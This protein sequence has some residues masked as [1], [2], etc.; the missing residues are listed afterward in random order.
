MVFY[1]G[2]YTRLGGA[3][4]AVCEYDSGAV[5]VKEEIRDIDDPIYLIFSPDGKYLFAVG[6]IKGSD[7]GAAASYCIGGDGLRLLS[8]KQTNGIEPCHMTL[9]AD[10]RFLYAAN[11]TTGSVAVLPVIEGILGEAVQMVRHEGK[12]VNPKRQERAHVHQCIFRPETNELFVC[13]LGIDKV[14]IYRQSPDT[15]MLAYESEIRMPDGMGPRHL[16]FYDKNRFFVVGELDNVLR[17]VENQ[18]GEWVITGEISTLPA[19]FS[20][21]STAA[22]L[23]LYKNAVWITNRGHDS[24]CRIELNDKGELGAASW[25]PTMGELP[26]DLGFIGDDILFANQKSGTVTSI[27]GI[28]IEVKGAVCITVP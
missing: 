19:D 4:I 21:V 2:T 27:S 6:N 20:G 12:G 8:V 5:T 3:G 18:S 11:Y 10:G 23:K 15:G 25:Q 26:R 13:D 16:A 24:L 7:E 9:S 14:M 22:A 1:T 28:R 17:V